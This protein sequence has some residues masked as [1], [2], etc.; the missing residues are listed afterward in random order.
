MSVQGKVPPVNVID[1]I[2]LYIQYPQLYT[3]AGE[4]ILE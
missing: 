1:V 3:M 2:I 4:L